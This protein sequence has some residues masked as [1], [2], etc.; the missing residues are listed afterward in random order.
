MTGRVVIEDVHPRTPEGGYPAKAVVGEAVSVSAAIFRDGH[1]ILAARVLLFVEG[2]AQPEEVAPLVLDAN[3]VWRGTVV[4]RRLGRHHLV[5]Q[6]W[7][8]RYA[9][10]AAKVDTKLH[11][12][13]DIDVEL[14]EG[15]SLLANAEPGPDGAVDPAVRAALSVLR[16]RQRAPGERVAAALSQPVAA[17]LAGPY[18][19]V[20]LTA[21]TPKSLWVDRERAAVGAWYELFPRSH[22][23]FKGTEAR[24]PELAAMGFDVLYLP[25]IHPIGTSHRKGPNNT[26]GAGPH[27]PGSPWAIG[28][29]E[30]GHTEI[31][32]DLG[33]LDDFA[34]LVAAV[35]DAGMELAL[36]YAL[37]CSP[38][39]PWVSAHPEWFHH[40][41]DGSI[42]YAENP[43]KKY[44][45]IYPINFWPEHEED[46]VALWRECKAIL[47]TWISRGVRI[48]RVDNPHTKPIAFWEW[49]IPSVQI[50]HPDVIFLAEAF[51]RPR[52]MSKLA[53][54]GFSQSYTYF[55]WRTAR[56]GEEGL[57]AYLEELAHGPTAEYLRPAFWPNTPDILADPLRDGPRAAFALRLVLAATASPTYGI[58]S[59][60]ELYENRPASPDNEEYLDS[61][62]YQIIVRDYDQEESLVPLITTLNTIRRR[63]PALSRL[64]SLEL[65]PSDNPSVIAYSKRSDDDRDA[66]LVV[67][68]LDPVRPQETTLHLDLDALGLPEDRPFEVVDELSGAHYFWR[69]DRPYIRLDPW[70]RVAHVFNLR[71]R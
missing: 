20:D 23:G 54:V 13:Q 64:R 24:V 10:W 51:T 66:L 68:N 59:G 39:H 33:T 48:F 5:I 18:G 44:Q 11:A 40:R 14:A 31:H 55:T 67:V 61:E 56:D 60:Y 69:G 7:T 1:D 32:P 46:R 29:P 6:A 62:K 58:Y 27:D 37:Q 49:V 45:D 4:P 9:T 42:A 65:H 43:P 15:E 22:G 26:L 47:D 41:P 52:M 30:G 21:C 38:D 71:H 16:D 34:H 8:D 3:D 53:E 12:E 63:H 36:D 57:W 70:E 25:P 2:S 28:S 17:A 35:N 19:A 50:E